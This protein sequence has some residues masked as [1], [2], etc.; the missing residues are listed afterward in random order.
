MVL[1]LPQDS[2]ARA[3]CLEFLNDERN[4]ISHWLGDI[5]FRCISQRLV[6]VVASAKNISAIVSFDKSL[7]YCDSRTKKELV[8]NI[9]RSAKRVFVLC[10]LSDFSMKS[11]RMMLE[12]D[13]VTDSELPITMESIAPGVIGSH[14]LLTSFLSA[15]YRL[16]DLNSIPLENQFGCEHNDGATVPISYDANQPISR[17]AAGTVFKMNIMP[18]REQTI[19]KIRPGT[20]YQGVGCKRS[21]N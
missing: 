6:N 9:A 11:L 20:R 8:A 1:Y 12:A 17:G 15:Q 5:V 2:R 7:R 18:P 14:S 16:I 19:P 10:I 13:P 21:T 3:I 4:L